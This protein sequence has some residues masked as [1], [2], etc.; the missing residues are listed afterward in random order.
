MFEL[1]PFQNA[2]SILFKDKFIERYSKLT[3]W[4][5][6]KKY[7]LSFLNKSIRVNTLKISLEE[8]KERISND[9]YIKQI[10]WC[11]E[12][13]W[14]EHKQGRLDVGNT[15]EHALGYYYVQEAA[16]MIP[17]IVLDPKENEVILDMCAAPGSKSS[18]IAQMMCNKGVLV[19]NDAKGIRLAS[20]GINLQRMGITNT[21]ISLGSGESLKEIKFDRILLDAPCSGTGTIR[22]SVKTI[23]M[24]N[25]QT[26]K[27]IQSLQRKLINNAFSLLKEGGVLVYSTCSTEPDEN[28]AVVDYF[29]AR[30]E[31]ARLKEIKIDIKRSPAVEEFDNKI[32]SQEVKKCLR[33]WPQDNNTEGFFVAKFVKE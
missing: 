30:E 31:S 8:L 18:Q 23:S 10:P 19:A 27:F 16:S 13:L 2:E 33:I 22:K 28:E 26:I 3:D 20:L 7:S 24:W 17:P 32:Y 29:L 25:P 14:V 11:E 15:I 5:E 21:V 1:K 9:W 12:G 6:Y 4:S